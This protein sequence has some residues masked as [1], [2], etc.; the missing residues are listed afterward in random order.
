MAGD[1][2]GSI[3]I[4]ISEALRRMPELCI[5]VQYVRGWRYYLGLWLMKAGARIISA[6]I[7]VEGACPPTSNSGS[8]CS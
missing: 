1:C 8:P 5:K 4:P 2:S 3:R 7:K 6:R